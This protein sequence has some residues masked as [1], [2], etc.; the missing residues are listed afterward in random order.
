MI[1]TLRRLLLKAILTGIYLCVVTPLAWLFRMLQ[2]K[3]L[4]LEIQ[5]SAQSYWVATDVR[6]WEK[7]VYETDALQGKRT[8]RL[9]RAL[10]I[11]WKRLAAPPENPDL[12]SD[13]Y[14]LF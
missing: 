14:V 5:P 2:K 8:T 6:S 1:K 7:A 4:A 12:S 11:P 13:L 9:V 10:L 3:P